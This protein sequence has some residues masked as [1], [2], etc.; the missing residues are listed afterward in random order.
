MKRLLVV[1][2][3]VALT[4]VAAIVIR[5]QLTSQ[6]DSGSGGMPPQAAAS[7]SAYRA[8]PRQ[9]AY[10]TE[11]LGTLKAVESVDITA[12]VSE[13]ISELRFRDGQWVEAGTILATL[14]HQE[15]RAQLAEAKANLTEQQR[16]VRRLED[17]VRTRSI[18]QS[19]LD[20][21][22]T[23]QE[24]A[25]FQIQAI[26]ARIDDRIIR[27][28]FSGQLGLRK[29]SPG[30]LVSPGTVITTLDDL[31]TMQLDFSV[32]ATLLQSLKVGQPVTASSPAFTQPFSGEV[33]AI[34]SRINPI[35]RSILVRA[36][37]HNPD[38]Q[39]KPGLLMN[40]LLSRQPRQALVIPEES[41]I[42]RETRQYVWVVD[43]T[44]LR[45]SEREVQTGGRQPGWVEVTSGL[46]PGE[47]IVRE[48]LMTARPGTVVTINNAGEL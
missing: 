12:N 5:E 29:V 40:V 11:A 6:T 31:R 8:H 17:L 45:V 41:L 15:E 42:S 44:S 4:A 2:I 37:F 10:Q 32:P 13:A 43:G 23:L 39:L 19:E 14:E 22:K 27:A 24:K 3:A 34:D 25:R 47:L 46:E 18:P 35:D 36:E 38:H 48:G 9:I 33:T 1:L 20:Q 16:E 21:R 26:E 28:P 7:I 30:A